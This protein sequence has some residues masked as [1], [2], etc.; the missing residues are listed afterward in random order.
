MQYALS[1]TH[2]CIFYNSLL[3]NGQAVDQ[4]E[5]QALQ[6]FRFA[7]D[8]DT[9][10]GYYNRSQALVTKIKAKQGDTPATWYYYYT[11]YCQGILA[12]LET[13]DITGAVTKTTNMLD[14][15]ETIFGA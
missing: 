8:K 7:M 2:N 4:E 15:L 1:Y 12:S 10:L 3:N 5:V 9:Q 11:E 14:S 13:N 6:N